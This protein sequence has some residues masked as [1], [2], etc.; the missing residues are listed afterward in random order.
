[1]MLFGRLPGMARWGARRSAFR[2]VRPRSSRVALAASGAC[3]CSL[4]SWATD[5][6]K[7]LNVVDAVAFHKCQCGRP[8]VTDDLRGVYLE[9]LDRQFEL[10]RMGA[11]D[12]CDG[13]TGANF[14]AIG[15]AQQSV[16]EF[17]AARI[18]LGD[19][20]ANS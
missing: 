6:L 11:I 1:M 20:I 17:A 15:W 9:W 5:Y 16:T 10:L 3:D 19:I 8:N 7:K 4:A 2:A 18:I 14:P 13:A 12:V